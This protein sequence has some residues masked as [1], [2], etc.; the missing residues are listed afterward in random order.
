MKRSILGLLSLTTVL[1]LSAQTP[2]W[3][4]TD[5][6]RR[7]LIAEDPTYLNREAALEQEIRQL[8]ANSAEQRDDET[9]Y[10]IP[11]VFHIIHLGGAENIT[12][13]QVLDQVDILNRDFRKLNPDISQVVPAFQGVAGDSRIE[14]RLPTLDPYGN[15]TN[16]IDRIRSI[17]TIVGNDG[18][19]LNPW[20]RDKYLNV[21]VVARMRDGVA[22]YAYYPGSLT[23]LGQ[24][25]DGI[26]ILNDYIGSIGTG[27]PGRSRALTHEVGHYLN[28]RHVWG[29]NNGVDGAPP[30]HMSSVCGDDAV[31]DTPFTRG[32]SGCPSSA[33]WNDCDPDILENVENYME[34]SFCSRM[35]TNGQVDRMRTALIATAGDRNNLWTTANLQATGISAGSEAQC[36]P[37]ADFIVQTV[38]NGA[39]VGAL[40]TLPTVCTGVNVF[41]KDNSTRSF[42]TNWSWTFQDGNP[43]TSEV[44]NP[45]VTFDSP[46]WKAVTL[47]VSNDHGSSSKTDTYAVLV[48]GDNA[49]MGPFFESFET[50]EGENLFPYFTANH[51][52]NH[53]SFRRYTGGGHTGSACALLNSG[54]RDQLD[55]IDPENDAD[56]DELVTPL[57]DLSG[58][59]SAV[60][61]FRWAYS[62]STTTTEDITE[63]LQ[64]F[65]SADCGRTWTQMPGE[66]SG[67]ALVNNGND[68]TIPPTQWSLRTIN[69]PSS[70]LT[71]NVRFKFRFISGSNSNDLFIDDINIATPVGIADLMGEDHISL[72]PNPTNDHFALHVAGMDDR[73]TEVVITDLRG[74]VVF[75]NMYLPMGQAT[76]DLS[77][78]KMGLTN[79]LYLLRASNGL[80]SRVKKLVVGQ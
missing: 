4:G 63:K 53:T 30:M 76:I 31:D 9:V 37:V 20:P 29:D 32:W 62:T 1:A 12:N 41:F 80:G 48:G 43:A 50:Q 19:K 57:V 14:F 77:A 36:G 17:E 58:V 10:V 74:A 2:E 73:A 6:V 60:L 7:R 67:T 28:L 71:A 26:I 33:T 56:I 5:E 61:A 11:I 54:D 55:L 52:N 22:G 16:G 35:F 64:V 65:R 27:N 18:S 42:P 72:F 40:P 69:I 8:L 66:I 39:T 25:A 44:R 13:E 38:A 21:W 47:T 24:L 75:R 3:C 49:A 51:D 45:I 23:G 34:Y 59:G 15:C 78:R 68:A 46:G 79:G 70:T